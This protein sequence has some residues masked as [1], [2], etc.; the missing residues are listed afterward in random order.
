MKFGI[1]T[2][3][4]SGFY[5]SEGMVEGR[6]ECMRFAVANI[7]DEKVKLLGERLANFHNDL[8][9]SIREQILMI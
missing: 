2:L 6:D 8:E 4:S 7:T 3:P 1:V 5:P 9:K